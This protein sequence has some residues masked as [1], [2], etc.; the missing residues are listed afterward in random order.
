MIVV[1]TAPRKEPTLEECLLSL[2]DCGW[3][4]IVVC[5]E[6]DSPLPSLDYT[7]VQNPTR[8]GTWRN[9]AA[10]VR[11]ALE[12]TTESDP[13]IMTVQ[14]DAYFHPESKQFLESQMWPENCGF[15]SLYT[16]RHYTVI[17]KTGELR[18]VGINRIYTK[19]LWGAVA[20]AFPRQVLKEISELPTM[21]HWLGAT[22]RSKDPAVFQKRRDNPETIANSDTA[23]GKMMNTKKY[24]MYFID[25]S[26]VTHIAKYSSISG[27]GSN[28]GNRNA[29]RAADH[30]L[31]LETQVFP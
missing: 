22:P 24:A 12:H 5:A 6:P 10:S 27:H 14:D 16:P 15:L 1:T 7:L 31:P 25:P 23:I 18:P 9:W 17:R 8:L 11:Y 19:S 2:Q 3:E 13:Y 28:D 21:D 20:L 4:D 29:Y 30:S 26:P